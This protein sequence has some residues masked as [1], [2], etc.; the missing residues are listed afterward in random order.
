MSPNHLTRHPKQSPCTL[1]RLSKFY[2]CTCE[3][4]V[5]LGS[6]TTSSPSS[7]PTCTI[8]P[9][10]QG[11][12]RQNPALHFKHNLP[13]NHQNPY[14]PNTNNNKCP[15][16]TPIKITPTYTMGENIKT[17]KFF[18]NS[19]NNKHHTTPPTQHTRPS[20]NTPPCPSNITHP[21]S[22]PHASKHTIHIPLI[23]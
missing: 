17:F 20:Y 6:I 7:S 1:L 19:A 10:K 16:K 8:T 5:H 23:T 15:T 2:L 13:P 11:L 9:T 4:T 12:H 18:Y 22:L 3:H 21:T 14:K